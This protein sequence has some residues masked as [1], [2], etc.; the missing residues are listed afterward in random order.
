MERLVT[1]LLFGSVPLADVPRSGGP[2]GED[3]SCKNSFIW[4]VPSE[5]NFEAPSGGTD[6][7]SV[8]LFGYSDTGEAMDI[9]LAIVS[10]DGGSAPF[11]FWDP[12]NHCQMVGDD[13]ATDSC[14][15]AFENDSFPLIPIVY[16]P[17]TNMPEQATGDG[18]DVGWIHVIWYDGATQCESV[19]IMLDGEIR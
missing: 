6:V 11:Q 14:V 3:S 18:F 4:A 10:D 12:V 19:P 5:V 13:V 15:I 1:F 2:G 7:E 17:G 8:A 9:E 16:Y